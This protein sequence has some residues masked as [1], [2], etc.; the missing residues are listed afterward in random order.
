[1]TTATRFGRVEVHPALRQLRVDG[2]EVS[3]GARAFDVL[4]A[5]LERR[6]RV[7][8]K[9]EL[10][11]LAWPGVVVEENNLQVQI[12]T[13]RRALGH[14]AIAT[15]AGRGY[16]FKLEPDGGPE[17]P[18]AMSMRLPL[19]V[20]SLIGREQEI[21][22]IA[23]MLRHRRLVSLVGAGGIGKT[24]LAL[25]IAH[26][27]APDYRDGAWFADLARLADP[28][29]VAGSV[30]ASLGIED[31]PGTAP[32]DRIR[33][34]VAPRH[35][36]LVLDNCEHLLTACGELAH[37]LLQSGPQVSILATSREPLHVGGESIYQVPALRTPDSRQEASLQA[38]AECAAVRVFLDRAAYASADFTLTR[39]NAAAIAQI[40]RE[41][42][43]IPLALEL[44]ASRVR[45]V[46]VA[47]IAQRLADRFH[48]LRRSDTTALPRHQTLRATLDWSYDLLS[49]DERKLLCRLSVFAG[50]FGVDAAEAIGNDAQA[51]DVLDLLGRL[52]DKSLVGF[53][54]GDA[55]YRM[56]ET[57]RQYAHDR[58]EESEA[59]SAARDAHMRYFAAFAGRAD[60]DE[61]S[62]PH[63]ADW[64]IRFEQER[65]NFLAMHRH[66]LHVPDGGAAGL[67]LA[68]MF[69]WLPLT[70][71]A[72]WLDVAKQALAH[73]GAQEA[74][75]ARCR[76]LVAAGFLAY[77][78]GQYQE[79]AALQEES[80]ALA[81]RIGDARRQADAHRDLGASL[82]GSRSSEA[83]PHLQAAYALVQEAGDARWTAIAAACI[84][85]AYA[86][87]GRYDLAEPF[88]AEALELGRGRLGPG[89]IAIELFNLVACDVACG[90]G[91]KAVAHLREAVPLGDAA[92][93]FRHAYFV[94]F[95]TALVAAL[96]NDGR[97]A[98]RLLGALEAGAERHGLIQ[99]PSGHA[100]TMA[101][102][103][104]ARALLDPAEHAAAWAAGRA[105]DDAG[106]VAE[107]SAWLAQR[108]A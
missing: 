28:Q 5:L 13:L 11:A 39:A 106:A 98:A 64:Q 48:V 67:A 101:A 25:G 79:A 27:V 2:V 12:S 78:L 102:I 50:G 69:R 9:D 54:G 35:L 38:L 103:A 57:V 93:S 22:D 24:S 21:A 68:A 62:G 77:V 36:L 96:L 83:L 8:T 45:S 23:E 15:V 99:E 95:S 34:H 16:R 61:L 41:V 14:D 20:A 33:R 81:V 92:R 73:P 51:E 42:D 60:D 58:L 47:V 100:V 66:A 18:S 55:R 7:V 40:C 87:Q 32:L 1:M 6:D 37:A 19:S 44:A 4:L 80:L 56:L 29:L 10:L 72:H 31:S 82:L 90:D 91:R 53:D 107:A 104:R 52:V 70:Q 85:E 76:A 17:S 49:E 63:Q 86:A 30:A 43:G 105:L 84:G 88:Y 65:D 108:D 94:V 75:I 71:H 97:A 89:D 74:S 59:A 3:L 46:P 26:S